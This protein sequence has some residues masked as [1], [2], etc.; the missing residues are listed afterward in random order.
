MPVRKE[1]GEEEGHGEDCSPES[2]SPGSFVLRPFSLLGQVSGEGFS[3]IFVSSPGV[4]FQV[5]SC[6][7]MGS[8]DW[9]VG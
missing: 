1:V 2:A 9:S 8:T 4:P 6:R 3:R 5:C 7:V